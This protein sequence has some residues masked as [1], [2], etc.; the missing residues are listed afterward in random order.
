MPH[1]SAG[2]AL[3]ATWCLQ[4]GQQGRKISLSGDDGTFNSRL[5]YMARMNLM[6]LI[7]F[8]Y[9]EPFNRHPE[10]G[11]FV[12]LCTIRESKDCRDVIN[13]LG[14]MVLHQFDNARAFF[15][16]MEWAVNEVMDN[17]HIHAAADVPGVVCAQ[18]YPTK[19][20]IE[21]GICDAGRGILASLR[22]SYTELMSDAEAIPLALQRGVTRDPQ[23]GQGN[24]LAGTLEIARANQGTFHIWSKTCCWRLGQ[25]VVKPAE[26]MP[27]VIGTAIHLRLDVRRPVNLGDTFI[28]KGRIDPNESPFL[29]RIEEEAGTD[30]LRVNNECDHVGSRPP[31]AALRR[32]VEAILSGFDRP[33]V[34]LD[35]ARVESASSSFLDELF[36]RLNVALG[37]DEFRKRI[38]VINISE[39]LQKMAEVVISQRLN[40]P[41]IKV[42]SN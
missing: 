8:D 3:L 35:F 42:T 32:K 15:P 37:Q 6:K 19:Y 17:I 7:G 38:R 11:R 16:A 10:A 34:I 20:V 14:D 13:S 31:A 1:A 30:G 25:G 21:V 24:G 40:S 36:G 18:Y 26:Q 33:S 22:E 41:L 12:P 23:I 2:L 28:A 29:N 9:Q 39:E 4:K 27:P 5:Q